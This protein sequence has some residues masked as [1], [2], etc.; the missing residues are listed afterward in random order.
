MTS[1][2]HGGG[3]RDA[4]LR[5]ATTEYSTSMLLVRS[6]VASVVQIFVGSDQSPRNR[7]LAIA[8]AMQ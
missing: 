2:G 4:G 5:V 8:R 6:Y 1:F 7:V 3:L